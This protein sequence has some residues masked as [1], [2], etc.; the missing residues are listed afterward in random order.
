MADLP[1]SVLFCCDHN[2]VRS[3][4]AEGAMKK[5]HGSRV[6]VQSC[7]VFSD[8]EVD[9]FM[10]AVAKEKGIDIHRHRSKSFD[11]MEAWG[12]DIESFDL[13][14]ALSPAAQRRALEYTRMFSI[15]VEYWPT[16]DPTSLGHTR[17]QKLSAYRQT[18]DQILDQIR[19]HFG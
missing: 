16:L 7:G 17:E 19:A 2:A 12:D 14:V 10:V 13:I 8:M 4:L 11:D 5:A 1:G 6:F 3:P 18:R 15:D 9:G